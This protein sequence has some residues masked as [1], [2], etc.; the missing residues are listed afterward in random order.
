MNSELEAAERAEFIQSVKSLLIPLCL[1]L[2]C[3]IMAAGVF[4]IY[5]HEPLGWA[6]SLVSTLMIISCMVAFIRFQNS[7][8][9]RGILKHGTDAEV[10]PA[11]PVAENSTE[12]TP[13]ATT[14]EPS[15][16]AEN[17]NVV[18]FKPNKQ[19]QNQ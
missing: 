3:V 17:S 9:A 19:R 8:R 5:N 18:E 6:F 2:A 15:A 10:I 14:A 7:Y 11:E 1:F 16:V 12:L 4:L 13:V